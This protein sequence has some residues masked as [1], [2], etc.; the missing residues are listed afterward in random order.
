MTELVD[1]ERYIM[2]AVRQKAKTEVDLAMAGTQHLA[3]S[4]GDSIRFPGMTQQQ[5][6]ARVAEAYK[7]LHEA[8]VDALIRDRAQAEVAD[9]LSDFEA[10]RQ[11]LPQT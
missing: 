6:R 4:V 7:L 8:L 10:Y 9:F 3:Q 5:A 1:I 11:Q 2:D